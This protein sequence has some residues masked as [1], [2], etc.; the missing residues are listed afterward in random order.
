M[1]DEETLSIV[2]TAFEKAVTLLNE[3][4]DKLHFVASFLIEHEIMDEEQFAEAMSDG[5]TIESV[6]KIKADKMQKSIDENA[7]KRESDAAKNTTANL[8]DMLAKEAEKASN[9]NQNND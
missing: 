6:E 1:I 7:K 5:A 2:N 8:A 9:R 4:M 3:H